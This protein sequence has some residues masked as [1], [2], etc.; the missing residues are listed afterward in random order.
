MVGGAFGFLVLQKIKISLTR[1]PVNIAMF[2]YLVE[3]VSN[4]NK[5]HYIFVSCFEE[6]SSF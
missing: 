1:G 3:A 5:T 4:T 6:A 2:S